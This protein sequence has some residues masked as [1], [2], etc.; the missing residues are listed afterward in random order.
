MRGT[1]VYV[2]SKPGY[3]VHLIGYNSAT[4]KSTRNPIVNAYL[5]VK[6]NNSISVLL[7]FNEAGYNAGGTVTFYLSNESESMNAFFT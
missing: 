5:K 3:Y 6:A 1:N 2:A 7:K 4:T